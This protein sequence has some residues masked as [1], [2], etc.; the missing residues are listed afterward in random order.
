LKSS[1]SELKDFYG[2]LTGLAY[3]IPFG[4]GGLYFGKLENKVN[5]KWATSLGLVLL[6]GIMMM[7]S[8]PNSFLALALSRVLLGFVSSCFN[9][10]G[11][12]IITD[13]FPP[14]RRGFAN[15]VV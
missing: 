9:P 8:I 15:S 1:Y 13:Y 7:V 11:F 6:A 12:S 10:L 14:D 2:I 4:V 3:T 5:R